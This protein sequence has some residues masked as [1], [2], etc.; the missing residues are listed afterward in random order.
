MSPEENA[1]GTAG[2]EMHYRFVF[3]V[4]YSFRV[5]LSHFPVSVV[6]VHNTQ[7]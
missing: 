4:D 5:D 1:L 3:V 2:A 7:L 6:T